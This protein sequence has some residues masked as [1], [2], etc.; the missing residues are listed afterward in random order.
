LPYLNLLINT[1]SQQL[2]HHHLT[3][4]VNKIIDDRL[5][6]MYL[7][8]FQSLILFLH[9]GAHTR[10]YYWLYYP[11][12][13]IISSHLQRVFNSESQEKN[14]DIDP[15]KRTKDFSIFD[16]KYHGNNKEYTR[17]NNINSRY[18]IFKFLPYDKIISMIKSLFFYLII[19]PILIFALYI[20]I[21]FLKSYQN[22]RKKI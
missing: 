7:R 19:P 5:E 17:S 6:A 4:I 10:L 22:R 3:P 9:K 18:T 15:V 16:W 8:Y 2:H 20:N 1:V 11:R 14:F 13:L 12:N 21:I